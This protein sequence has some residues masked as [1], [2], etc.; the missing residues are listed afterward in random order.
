M[1]ATDEL[2]WFYQNTWEKITWAS[3]DFAT[4]C[5]APSKKNAPSKKKLVADPLK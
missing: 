5:P 4:G 2:E 3:V 1:L